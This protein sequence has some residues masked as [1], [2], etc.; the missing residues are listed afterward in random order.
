MKNL[1]KRSNKRR[2]KKGNRNLSKS[3]KSR[4]PGEGR[5]SKRKG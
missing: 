4:W 3:D 5:A 1:E 2:Q